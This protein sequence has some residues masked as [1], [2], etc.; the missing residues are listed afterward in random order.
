MSAAALG[1]IGVLQGTADEQMLLSGLL[2]GYGATMVARMSVRAWISRVVL[3]TATLPLSA[4]ALYEGRAISLLMAGSQRM[5]LIGSLCCVQR[6]GTTVV[7]LSLVYQE[8]LLLAHHNLLTKPA[9]RMG[10][11]LTHDR[12]ASD[13]GVAAAY[14]LAGA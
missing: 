13:T 9:K 2:F 8:S 4:T 10:P 11:R 6:P 5:V 14:H 1:A 12:S 7:G 3:P